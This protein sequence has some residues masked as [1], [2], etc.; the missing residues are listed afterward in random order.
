M[1]TDMT[2][3]C[4]ECG[5]DF[6][7]KSPRGAKPQVCY[8]CREKLSSARLKSLAN[9]KAVPRLSEDERLAEEKR[10]VARAFVEDEPTWLDDP[11]VQEQLVQRQREAIE[12]IGGDEAEVQVGDVERIPECSAPTCTTPPVYPEARPSFCL[13]HWLQTDHGLRA[14]LLG[15]PVGSAPWNSACVK[16]IRSLR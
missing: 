16:A 2:C 3:T 7:R 6:Q 11:A 13:N 10:E 15:A 5:Q 8:D 14:V 1:T 12:I 9:V 4:K